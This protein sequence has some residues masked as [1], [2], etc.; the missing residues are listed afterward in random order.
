MRSCK[1]IT[2]LASDALDQD[3]PLMTRM[4]IRMHLWMCKYCA[5]YVA[6]LEFIQW[7]LGRWDEQLEVE[8][9]E[10]EAMPD[11]L[12]QR[13]DELVQESADE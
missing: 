11:D 6:Q 13:L 3:L 12:R 9:E 1:E 10:G 5:R 7:A 4:G 8:A 2:R